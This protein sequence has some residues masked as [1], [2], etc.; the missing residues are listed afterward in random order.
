MAHRIFGNRFVSRKEPAWH[1]LGTIFP[2]EEVLTPSEAVKRVT[3]DVQFVRQPLYYGLPGED[4]P[5]RKSDSFVIL[6]LPTADDPNPEQIGIVSER[7][8]LTPYHELAGA[9]D[10][11][12]V[13]KYKVE[14]AGLLMGGALCFFALRGEDWS[15]L[16][17]DDMRSYFL[18]NLSLKPGIGHRVL[19]TTVRVVCANTNEA[20]I[21]SSQIQLRIPHGADAKQ[22]IGLCGDLVA[23]FRKAQEETKRVFEI[24]A[25]TPAPK[26]SVDKVFAAAWPEPKLPAKIK[27]LH[28]VV[29]S[30]GMEVFKR[31]LDPIMLNSL[32]NAQEGYDREV[33]RI[34]TMRE[35]GAERFEAFEPRDLGG[36]IW[37]AYNAVTEVA[38]WRGDQKNLGESVLIGSRAAE[39]TRAFGAAM[40]VCDLD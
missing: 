27:M 22:Q 4:K 1:G 34:R 29:G 9:L 35:A 33:E 26:D 40:K 13:S 32:V 11:M 16:G 7:W 23:R 24:F 15:V 5:D 18:T 14:T 38:D 21:S 39:K 25:S 12:D 8:D 20:A 10:K 37:A 6:R 19:H 36:T 17:K 3:G 30:E 28:N 2:E 31:N